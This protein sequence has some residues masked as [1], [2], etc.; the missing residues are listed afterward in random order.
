MFMIIK[1]DV[2]ETTKKNYFG[3]RIDTRKYETGCEKGTLKMVY[4]RQ[5]QDF[6]LY[7]LIIYLNDILKVDLYPHQ[8]RMYAFIHAPIT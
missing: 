4:S 7:R 2:D 5:R 8:T 6:W 3:V 1:R